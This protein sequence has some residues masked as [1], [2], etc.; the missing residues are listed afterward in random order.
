ME[1]VEG[2]CS[3]KSVSNCD[4]DLLLRIECAISIYLGI[5]YFWDFVVDCHEPLVGI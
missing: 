1:V 4:L 5:A 3:L 2:D